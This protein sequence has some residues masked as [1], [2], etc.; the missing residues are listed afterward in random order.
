[1]TKARARKALAIF[2]LSMGV[3]AVAAWF[4]VTDG[5]WVLGEWGLPGFEGMVAVTFGVMGFVIARRTSNPTGFIFTLLGV[6]SAIQ[7]LTEAYSDAALNPASPLP[8]VN[9]TAWI[10]EWIWVPLVGVVGLLLLVFPDDRIGSRPGRVIL[11]IGVVAAFATFVA[12]AF[13]APEIRTWGVDNPYA[14]NSEEGLYDV[15]FNLSVMIFMLSLLAAAVRLAARLR[16]ATGVRKQQLKW[17]AYAALFASIG[18]VFG[19]IPATSAVGSGFAVLGLIGISIASA[20]AIL[21][22]RLYDIDLVINRTLVY[23][24]LTAVLAVLYVVLVFG[25]QALL[26][27]FTA[28]SD[29]AIAGST[30]A[31]AALFRPVRARVQDFIDRRFYRSKFDAERTLDAF[32][33]QVRD[34]VDIDAL[35]EQLTKVVSETMQPAH[36]SLWLRDAEAQP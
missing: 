19:A 5:A 21:K 23:G 6:G 12:S 27:P 8:G 35:S 10:A 16:R 36:V 24:A 1:M 18:L 22:Y 14:I 9:T 11:R 33:R 25:F 26:S 30:L 3:T 28:D 17:F 29:L 15:T 34:Q 13:M 7:Y 2:V 31:V 4:H 20:I 32:T